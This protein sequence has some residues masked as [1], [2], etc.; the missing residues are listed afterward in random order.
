M[1]MVDQIY[2]IV[3]NMEVDN[4]KGISA[5]DVAKII[6]LDRSNISRYLNQLYKEK[7]LKKLDGRPVLYKTTDTNSDMPL[8]GIDKNT[9]RT[10]NGLDKMVGAKHSLIR[11]IEKAKAAIM[12][13]PKGLH[14][15][16]LGDTGVGKSLFAEQMYYYAK[17]V[18]VLD[19]KA[20]FIRFNCADYADNPNLLTGQIFGVK[21]GAYTGA[22]ENKEG[23]LK[24]AD[25]GILF[26]DEVHRLP[27]HGQE[28]LFTYIDKGFFRALGDTENLNYVD[29]RIIAATT[30]DPN[31][32]LLQTFSRRIPM[33][34]T[35]PNLSERSLQERYSLI[36]SFIK[37]E[38]HR[39]GN[40]IYINKNSI[41]SYLLYDCPNNIGQLKSD[42][43]LACAKA[44]LNYKSKGT[45]YL[46]INQ[47]DLPNH[48]RKGILNLN[49][50]RKEVDKLL[51]N[52]HDILRFSEVEETPLQLI[53][54]DEA[55][56]EDFYKIMEEKIDDLKRLGIDD[57]SINQILNVDI[58]SQFQ[59]Y[60]GVISQNVRGEEL[61]NL[62]DKDVLAV[63]EEILN[64]AEQE[65]D[66]DYNERIYF[67]L[68]FHLNRSI[69]RIRNGEDIFNP[70]LNF[71]RINHEKEFIF[72][73]KI[74]KIL[75]ERFTIET[76]VDEIGYLAMFFATDSFGNIEKKKSQVSIIVAMHG[77]STAS[78]MAEVVNSLIGMEKAVPLDM[79]LTMKPKI[80]YEI[81]K[82]K[83]MEIDCGKGVI[84]LVDMGSLTNFGHMITEE[85]GI[86]IRT[87]DMAS[88]LTLLDVARKAIMGYDIDEII[89]ST[90]LNKIVAKPHNNKL[91]KK[92]VIITACFTGDGSANKLAHI[93]HSQ[94]QN[95]NI[96]MIPMNIIDNSSLNHR[97][98]EMKGDYNI[99]AIVSTIDIEIDGI[100][101]I[102]ALDILNSKGIGL[103]NEIIDE[104]N[105]YRS[106]NNSLVTHLVNISG[107]QIII[108]I[109]N[110]INIIGRELNCQLNKDVK[111]GIVLHI[112]FL[113]DNLIGGKEPRPFQKL[114]EFK[115]ENGDYM[116]IIKKSFSYMESNYK[117]NLGDNEIAHILKLFLE[118][119]SV[120]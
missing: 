77:R 25:K 59:K 37:E 18:Q 57:F 39:V 56:G 3:L 46:I 47:G 1:R 79:P 38:T 52:T 64:L 90:S 33:I 51:R 91:D 113:I 11:P 103:L 20:P 88:T 34:I 101:F 114:K 83:V 81:T 84:L 36:E 76:P 115:V 69:E 117:V 43:Q 26:L 15:M 86:D 120:Q 107:N 49:D 58:E 13:P 87:I 30:E 4:P 5:T 61:S 48:V 65:L 54:E 22:D 42:I 60:I 111:M 99:I 100:P 75:D 72:A 97:I 21:K 8:D 85:T 31:S 44:F 17:E 23:L 62:V 6:D 50:Y 16:I 98:D 14:T 78:S 93:I 27:P 110:L 63:V 68:S 24:Q 71:I 40:T 9:I 70:K 118:N 80:M 66:K 67:G 102:S 95:E 116:D 12:Y 19:F 45:E 89:N 28:M 74:A 53:H 92:D 32:Y 82:N 35:L 2:E 55:L 109:K 119:H 7:R 108:D 96:S 105:M 104:E 112:S 94:I 29:V 41:I 73:T 10:D 106:V